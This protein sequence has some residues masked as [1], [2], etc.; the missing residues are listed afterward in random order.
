MYPKI[1][2]RFREIITDLLSKYFKKSKNL[3]EDYINSL[4]SQINVAHPIFINAIDI[5][6]KKIRDGRVCFWAFK[7]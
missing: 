1:K 3:I 4:A 5:E 6:S 2:E 7:N